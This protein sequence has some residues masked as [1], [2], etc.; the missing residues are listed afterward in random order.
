M[1]K[2]ILEFIR[3]HDNGHFKPHTDELL[4]LVIK[5]HLEYGTFMVIRNKKEEIVAVA[6]WNFPTDYVVHILDVV[7]KKDYRK[8]LILRQMLAVGINKHPQVRTM[9]YERLGKY[10]KRKRIVISVD[11][12]LKKEATNEVKN[13]RVCK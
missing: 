2:E 12:F 9:I 3:K 1:V 8:P 5:K 7:V 11:K 10:P 4:K 6:R 13:E